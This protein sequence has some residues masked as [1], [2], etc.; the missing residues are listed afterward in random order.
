MQRVLGE[1]REL[2][3]ETLGVGPSNGAEEPVRPYTGLALPGGMRQPATSRM[4][5]RH[6]WAADD[7]RAAP[8]QHR[9]EYVD[10]A[11]LGDRDD[12]IEESAV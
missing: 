1:R 2:V 3:A 11:R 6:H 5:L 12:P 8:L 9:S 10:L 4:A 7:P